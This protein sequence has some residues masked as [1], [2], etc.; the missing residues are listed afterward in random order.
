MKPPPE[1]VTAT[2][3]ELDAIL[4]Q[5]KP[6]LPL[7][8]YQ[9]L[10]GVL[11][12]LEFMMLRLQDA[13]M[14]LRRLQRMLFGASTE[15]QRDVIKHSADDPVAGVQGQGQALA[16]AQPQPPA[17]AAPGAAADTPASPPRKGHGRNGAAA[18]AG[19]TQV[20]CAHQE[21]QSGQ[22]CPQCEKGKVYASPPKVIVKVVGQAPLAAAVYQVQRLRCRV[23]DVV[24]TAPVPAAALGPK[25]E[26]SCASMIAMMRYG[27]GLPSYRLQAL[28][29]SLHVPLPDAT[30]W[31]I[32]RKALPAPRCVHAELMYQAA[33]APLLYSD[34]TPM[35]VL[36]PNKQGKQGKQ[37]ETAGPSGAPG[38][39]KAV[40]EAV[41]E[42][43]AS[44][45]PKATGTSCIVAQAPKYEV[46]LYFTGP[47]HAGKNMEKVQALRAPGLPPPVY[48]CD[49]LAANTA[50]DFITVLCHCLSHGRRR[51][52]D[53]L[54]QFPEQGRHVLQVLGRVYFHDQ[55]C[56][57]HQFDAAQRLEY[58]Q[59]HSGPLMQALKAWMEQRIEQREVEPSSGLGKALKYL[60]RHWNELTLF[61]RHAGAP[62]DNNLC[63]Q[64]IKRAILHR[65][66][67][68]FYQTPAGA[69]AGD[70]YMSLIS[71]CVRCG[72]N[73]FDYLQALHRN[74]QAVMDNPGQWLPWNWRQAPAPE[75]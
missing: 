23:C 20:E 68:M 27:F 45:T 58:H 30:Q 29:A 3:S 19:A 13:R 52:V 60:L 43:A 6:V 7:P 36:K 65:K 42:E 41:P 71:T 26:L 63:E 49:A 55:H 53:V 14:S 39:P 31:D 62:L 4:A 24:F 32:I 54:E 47:A 48:M 56:R 11:Q 40:A 75:G 72:Q 64:M 37:A 10:Q 17:E 51:V 9:L 2:R 74:A 69:E 34:D 44:A 21:M 22:L 8:Q 25:Y 70:I 46:V 18:Y 38:E 57:E 33:Q 35:R 28:Q 59:T 1:I 12:T 73:A 15:R 67:S 5:V 66:G 61:L 16:G 50:G